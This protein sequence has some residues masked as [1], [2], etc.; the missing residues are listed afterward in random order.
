MR[1]TT[2]PGARLVCASIS[3]TRSSVGRTMGRV[4]V[5]AAIDEIDG[6]ALQAFEP[7][8]GRL[9]HDLGWISDGVQNGNEGA[10]PDLAFLLDNVHRTPLGLGNRPLATRHAAAVA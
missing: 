3:S 10:R 4:S 2:S 5:Q 7:V 8:R 6:L 9:A 1:P